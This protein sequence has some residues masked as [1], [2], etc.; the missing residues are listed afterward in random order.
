MLDIS[1][2]T[3]VMKHFLLFGL[4]HSE[5]NVDNLLRRTKT[6]TCGNGYHWLY[7]NNRSQGQDVNTTT[8]GFVR[9]LPSSTWTTLNAV[10]TRFSS[11]TTMREADTS[12][13]R[14]SHLR[15]Q[16][17]TVYPHSIQYILL[18]PSPVLSLSFP[19]AYSIYLIPFSQ[20]SSISPL[21]LWWI[22]Y[23]T[24]PTVP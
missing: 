9:P 8:R 20:H 10:Y 21:L 1:G 4:S 18:F 22:P 11:N 3:T 5:M 12:C 15:E 19:Y 2:V 23:S 6:F 13:L 16:R 24:L 17:W 14:Q 7:W